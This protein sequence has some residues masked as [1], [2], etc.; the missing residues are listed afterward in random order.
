MRA[1]SRAPGRGLRSW[2]KTWRR[3][4]SGTAHSIAL[5]YIVLARR[6]TGRPSIW[7]KLESPLRSS[8]P[9][10]RPTSALGVLAANQRL[11]S[12][13][14]DPT[15]PPHMKWGTGVG[16]AGAEEMEVVVEKN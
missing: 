6:L 9:S 2:M 14:A 12:A 7:T 13:P 8:T 16:S 11:Q 5:R 10:Q 15:P 1:S 4:A 3:Y